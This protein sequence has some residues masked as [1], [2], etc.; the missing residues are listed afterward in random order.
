MKQ[1]VQKVLACRWYFE[2]VWKSC[3]KV[4]CMSAS[5]MGVVY[6]LHTHT[7][8]IPYNTIPYH[9]IPTWIEFVHLSCM[10]E[11][12][13]LKKGGSFPTKSMVILAPNLQCIDQRSPGQKRS[14][15]SSMLQ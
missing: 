4:I 1:P 13:P 15:A 14:L 3:S 8:H 11:L 9:T 10:F 12:E 7:V 6:S 2:G 5:Y